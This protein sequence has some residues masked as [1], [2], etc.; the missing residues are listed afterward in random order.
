[1]CIMCMYMYVVSAHVGVLFGWLMYSCRPG[2][3]EP[4]RDPRVWWKVELWDTETSLAYRV[5][6]RRV[7]ATRRNLA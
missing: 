1:M 6:S 3:P 2:W 7:R 5:I 4:H